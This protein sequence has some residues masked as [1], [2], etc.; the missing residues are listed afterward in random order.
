MMRFFEGEERGFSVVLGCV[1][2][3]VLCKGAVCGWNGEEEV[4]VVPL[5]FRFTYKIPP[6][7]VA[8]HN[9][10]EVRSNWAPRRV[11]VY[12][13]HSLKPLSCVRLLTLSVSKCSRILRKTRGN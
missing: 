10:F 5:L 11:L 9:N 7:F 8:R 12:I 1:Y 6:A 4:Q 13:Y 2:R 3:G